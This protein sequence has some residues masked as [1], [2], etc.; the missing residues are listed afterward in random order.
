VDVAPLLDGVDDK[1]VAM[2]GRFPMA[3]SGIEFPPGADMMGKR[4]SN[5]VRAESRVVPSGLDVLPCRD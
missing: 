2:R 4:K 3:Q 5:V 1:P